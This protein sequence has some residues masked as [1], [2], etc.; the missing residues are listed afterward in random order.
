M[1]KAEVESPPANEQATESPAAETSP[2]AAPAT[3]GPSA[4]QPQQQQQPQPL[5]PK[6]GATVHKLDYDKD[7]VYLYQFSR[8]PTLPSAS[9]YCLK[10]ETWLRMAGLKYENVDHKLKFKSKKG[11]LPFVELNGEEIADSD[12]IIKDLSKQFTKDLDDD[13]TTEQRNVSHAFISMLSNHTIWVVRWWRYNHPGQFLKTTQVDIK[14]TLNS[15]LPKGLLQFVFKMSLKSNIKQAVSHGL[16]RHTSEEIID[17][18]KNDLKI[19][20]ETLADKQYFFG[21]EPHLLDCTAFAYLCQFYYVPFG[22]LKE[23]MESDCSNLIGFL[24]RMKERYWPDW[25][26]ICKTL[27]L[28]THLPKKE[29]KPEVEEK[30]EKEEE[31]KEKE[32]D[33]KEEKKE[34][35]EKDKASETEEKDKDTEKLQENKPPQQDNKETEEKTEKTKEE[36]E[37]KE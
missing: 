12:I 19:L 13:L 24:G 16:G 11:Q 29:E 27:E 3:N 6:K 14:R 35:E 30:T 5:A 22:G 15:K 7:V 28:N 31:K 33:E 23:F 37:Q 20:S 4:A 8:F 2:A 25:D 10:M 21:D 18:G 17:F 36:E 9:P 1:T 32:E 34:S 26:E